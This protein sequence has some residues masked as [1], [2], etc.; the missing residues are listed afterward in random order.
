MQVIKYFIT[1][2]ALLL[3]FSGCIDP[4]TPEVEDAPGM[5]VISGRI[6][7]QE[8]YQMVEVSTSSSYS[9]SYYN[10]LRKCIVTIADDKDHRF[11]LTEYEPGR[12]RCWIG[13]EYLNQGTYYWVEVTTPDGKQYKSDSETLLPCPS[14]ES[15]HYETKKIDT[16]N[17]DIAIYGIQFYVNTDA[18][19]SGAKNFLWNMT[20]TWEYHST[21]MVSDYYDG[22][23]HFADEVFDSIY[24]CWS[25]GT[26]YDIYTFTTENLASGKITRCPLNFVSS[27]SSRLSVKYSML[28]SQYS[29]SDNAYHYWNT[30]QH[31]SQGT[32]GFYETQPASITGNIH[33]LSDPGEI[34]LGYFMASSVT[35]KRIF[36]PRHYDFIIYAPQCDLYDFTPSELQEFLKAFKKKD[37]PIFLVNLS[38]SSDGPWDFAEQ[39]CFDCRK[40][41]GTVTKPDFWE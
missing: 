33:C 20:E 2:M 37:Y 6:T 16:E 18:T 21:Y 12:Y 11:E 10:P 1:G 13:K 24:Y 7:D 9:N 14:I 25:S 23:I 4:F 32:G 34:V 8:G 28:V 5:M 35:Q 40:L 15:I 39:Y 36:V 27:K 3:L 26:I 19:G 41:G 38:F 22:E 17:P 29:I 31:Q 30:L